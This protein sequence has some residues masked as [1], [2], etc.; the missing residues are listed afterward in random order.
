MKIFFVFLLTVN[1]IY[2]NGAT[3]IEDGINIIK[4]GGKFESCVSET[5]LILKVEKI[6]KVTHTMLSPSKIDNLYSLME[7]AVKEERVS[8]KEQFKYISEYKKLKHG[9]ELLLACLKKTSCDLQK[10]TE[11]IKNTYIPDKILSSQYIIKGWVN[12]FKVHR[13]I[14]G[15][16]NPM[17]AKIS[18][19]VDL[20]RTIKMEYIGSRHINANAAGFERN[21]KKFWQQ[22]KDKYPE[23]LSKNNQ[24]LIQNG[25]SPIVDKQWIKYNPKHESFLGQ[26]LEHHHLNNTDVAVG[27]P[28]L[29]HRGTNNKELMHVDR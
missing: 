14:D 24:E 28:Q 18:E 26:K 8:Y 20:K 10:Y 25:Y 13:F 7:L 21:A 5:N 1:L 4:N 19:V 2:S 12:D 17:Y 29:L 22:Y 15:N 27:V 3:L 11:L 9:D 23:A 6:S 16:G